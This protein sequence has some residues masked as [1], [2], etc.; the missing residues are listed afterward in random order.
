[1]KDIVALICQLVGFLLA[2]AFFFS[3]GNYFFGWH[4]GLKGQEVPGDPRAAVLF[5]VIAAVCGAI[6]YFLGR[7]T[8]EKQGK[9]TIS[10][11]QRA[12]RRGASVLR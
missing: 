2:L 9:T 1:M 12:K 8:K 7:K 10:E 4:L 11:G 6:A 5:L 3:L